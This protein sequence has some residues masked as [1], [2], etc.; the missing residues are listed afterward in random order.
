MDTNRNL[1]ELSTGLN[2]NKENQIDALSGTMNV[3]DMMSTDLNEQSTTVPSYRKDVCK[4]FRRWAGKRSR[5]IRRV[6]HR[7]QQNEN[8]VEV[9]GKLIIMLIHTL[10]SILS[11]RVGTFGFEG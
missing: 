8:H 2:D 10:H 6:W 1:S 3:T 7:R 5:A 4:R 11:K 9:L